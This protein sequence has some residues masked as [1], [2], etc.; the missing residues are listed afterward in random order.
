M[1]L[2]IPKIFNKINIEKLKN[3]MVVV[4]LERSADSELFS[5]HPHYSI[6][7]KLN[8]EKLPKNSLSVEDHNSRIFFNKKNISRILKYSNVYMIFL[9]N[10]QNYDKTNKKIIKSSKS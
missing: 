8:I 3:K 7:G 4:T 10:C 2:H 5:K 1:K 9:K 6:Q